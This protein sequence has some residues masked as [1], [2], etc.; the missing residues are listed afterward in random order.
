MGIYLKVRD[1]P[2]VVE[3]TVRQHHPPGDVT[4]QL[5]LLLL[6]ADNAAVGPSGSILLGELSQLLRAVVGVVHFLPATAEDTDAVLVPGLLH[7]LSDTGHVPGLAVLG[8]NMDGRLARGPAGVLMSGDSWLVITE[9][10][11]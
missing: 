10:G 6:L 2:D 4:G 7:L 1:V 3:G 9:S 11:F 8:V 5:Y